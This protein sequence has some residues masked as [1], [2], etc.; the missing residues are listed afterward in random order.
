MTTLTVA[1]AQL[2]TGAD[3]DANLDLMAGY[4]ERA[5]ATG[6]QLVVFP[7]AA[8]RCFGLPLAE[9]AE[10]VDGPWA[11]R[12]ARI[13]TD[14]GVVVLAGMFTPGSGGRV[15]NTLLAVGPGVEAAYDK[16]HLYDAYGFAESDTVEAGTALVTVLVGGVTVG[17]T[18]CYDVR[19]PGVYTGLAERGATV[20]AVASSWGAGPGKV[21]Q[22]QVLTR[23]RALDSTTFVLA[24]GQADPEVAG[25][26]H[27]ATA[28]TGVGFSAVVSPTGGVLGELGAEPGLLTVTLDLTEIDT[29]RAALPVLANRRM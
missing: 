24:A 1:L 18:T 16:I 29:A 21:D 13:A 26:P 22:W 27:K 3:P 10:P 23:A 11:A 2:S 4:V 20:I 9:I 7:E 8:M 17:L 28:P 19:F 5:A 14:A 12:L 15:R 6:A 25:V